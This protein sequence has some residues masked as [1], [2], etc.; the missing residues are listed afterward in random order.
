VFVF[1]DLLY[2]FGAAVDIA[3]EYLLGGWGEF[4]G[5]GAAFESGAVY[6]DAAEHDL[7]DADGSVDV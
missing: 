4:P 6:V 3:G 2:G 5:S 1:Y 7:R